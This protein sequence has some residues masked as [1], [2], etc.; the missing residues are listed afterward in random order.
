M[1][2][3]GATKAV[4]TGF[5]EG[6]LRIARSYLKAA[7][8]EVAMSGTGDIGN[9]AMSQIVNAA[10]AYADALTARFAG[11]I[12]RADHAAVVKTM[13]DALGNR[14]PAAQ[15]SRLRSILDEKDETQY[16]I[17]AKSLPE[18][19]SLLDKLEKFAEWAEKELEV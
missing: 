13:R 3:R 4:E 12:N 15:A 14:L 8:L 2:R 19:E 7:R 17:R 9:P 6:R 10:I 1:T 5:G 18:A 16:G 11:K